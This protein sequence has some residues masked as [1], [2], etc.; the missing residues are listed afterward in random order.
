MNGTRMFSLIVASA[1]ALAYA[2]WA[3]SGADTLRTPG[4]LDPGL[5]GLRRC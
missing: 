4:A 2:A 5:T 1:V 3:A